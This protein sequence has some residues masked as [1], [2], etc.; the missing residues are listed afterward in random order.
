MGVGKMAARETKGEE[1]G[2]ARKFT[3][4]FKHE[5]QKELKAPRKWAIFH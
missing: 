5:S 4:A 1:D 2:R 3:D